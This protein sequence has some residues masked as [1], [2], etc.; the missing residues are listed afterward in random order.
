MARLRAGVCARGPAESPQVKALQTQVDSMVPSGPRASQ[1]KLLVSH[2]ATTSNV[3]NAKNLG[4]S[5]GRLMGL[6]L[7]SHCLP[8]KGSPP[9]P[10][11]QHNSS[12]LPSTDPCCNPSASPPSPAASLPLQPASPAESCYYA[13]PCTPA[14]LNGN[15][16]R[17]SSPSRPAALPGGMVVSRM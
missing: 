9:S 1:S 13:P 10:G 4:L 2:L 8:S 6:G 12:D 16:C 7:G 3:Y 14:W 11:S 5:P 15:R 17:V